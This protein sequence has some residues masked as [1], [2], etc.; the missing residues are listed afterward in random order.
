MSVTT[1][2]AVQLLQKENGTLRE[3]IVVLRRQIDWLK[4][5]LFGPGQSE[6]LDRA[7]LLLHLGELEQL[8]QAAERPPQT[9]SYERATGPAPKRTLPA[10]SFAHLPVQETV[11][12]EPPAVQADLTLYE[13]IGEERTFEVDVV[14]P[15]LFKREIVRPKYRH[16]L[17]RNRAP[18]LTARPGRGVPAPPRFGRQTPR[19]APKTPRKARRGARTCSQTLPSEDRDIKSAGFSAACKGNRATGQTSEPFI[20]VCSRSIRGVQF[21]PLKFHREFRGAGQRRNVQ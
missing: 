7:Q 13:K 18:L 6:K 4:Q 11:V 12:I 17:D 2:D 10:E 21:P 20:F 15:K 9:I 16:R 3:E 8:V 5:K 19:A 1:P 14:P